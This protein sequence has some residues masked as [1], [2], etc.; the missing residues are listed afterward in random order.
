MKAVASEVTNGTDLLSLVQGPERVSG[1][2]DDRDIVLARKR[3]DGIHV[4]GVAAYVHGHDS[5]SPGCDLSGNIG[6]IDV[7]GPL[8]YVGK[9]YF[10]AD[11]QGP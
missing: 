3:H 7:D 9:D 8:V 1:I 4:G 11:R 5:T 6:G 10:G 2:L